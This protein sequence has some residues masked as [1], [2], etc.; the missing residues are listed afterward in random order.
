MQAC[1]KETKSS[2]PVLLGLPVVAPN[3][4]PTCLIFSPKSLSNS[5]GKGPLPTLVVYAF[6]TPI[7]FS[8][9]VGGTPAPAQTPP[10]EGDD[11]VT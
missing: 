9:A 10:V 3:S 7:R 2:H 11:E 1:F 4:P 6:A 8:N 5:V